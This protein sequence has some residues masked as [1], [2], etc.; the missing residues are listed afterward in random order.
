MNEN[1]ELKPT[2]KRQANQAKHKRFL[3]WCQ[4]NGK[5][6]EDEGA[7]DDFNE[8]ESSWEDMDEDNENGWTDNMTKE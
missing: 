6:P 3:E 2:E 5:D 7:L 1:D 4:E 8:T